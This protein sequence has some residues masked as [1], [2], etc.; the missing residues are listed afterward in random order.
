MASFAQALIAN[1]TAGAVV[2]TLSVAPAEIAGNAVVSMLGLAGWAIIV[3]GRWG[4]RSH[5]TMSRPQRSALLT[6]IASA[7]D[8]ERQ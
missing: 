4:C 3:D 6:R 7:V 8:E 1:G 2:A 5:L